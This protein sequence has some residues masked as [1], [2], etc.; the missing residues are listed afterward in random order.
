MHAEAPGREIRGPGYD[1][2]SR[3]LEAVDPH[4]STIDDYFDIAEPT[5]GLGRVVV[6]HRDRLCRFGI[7]LVEHLFR[8]EETGDGGGG[9][10]GS[11]GRPG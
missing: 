6:A 9:C 2:M 1:R 8:K 4:Q 11:I 5:L 10:P 7:E 3:S